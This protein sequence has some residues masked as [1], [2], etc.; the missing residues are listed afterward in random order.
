[1]SKY[2]LIVIL[3]PTASGKTTLATALA[4]Q[5]EGEIISA[6]SRQVYRGMTIGT[7]KDLEDYECCGRSIPYHLID[8][9]DPGY[10]YNVFEFQKDF[11]QAYNTIVVRK[12]QPI[13]CGGTGMYLDSVL[14]QYPLIKVSENPVLRKKIVDYSDSELIQLLSS[15]KEVHNT[16]D[17]QNR[18]RLIRAI[19]IA[20]YEKEHH[21]KIEFP[22][23]ERIVFGISLD[24]N[25]I[26]SR[27]SQRLKARV[28]QGMIEEVEGLL[29][30]VSPEK[31]IFYGLEYKYLTLYVTGE[32]SKEE[33]YSKLETA[34]HQFAKRQM[35]W[36]R[37]MEKRGTKIHWIDGLRPIEQKL[38]IIKGFVTTQN[39]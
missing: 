4:S 33:M 32:I 9:V 20:N 39:T 11:L 10:E 14:E 7:G 19:E 1:M 27:I 21:S 36:F 29:Q 17:L 3:G 22:F 34:I 12:K 24:R 13:L 23:I 30:T 6:D 25:I 8:I 38:K 35:T 5:M 2:Q 26:R 18:E 15:L 28:E 31:L 37:R 16:T